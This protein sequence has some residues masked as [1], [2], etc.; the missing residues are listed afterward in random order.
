MKYAIV[1]LLWALSFHVLAQ[2][3]CLD[4]T[5]I[6][7]GIPTDAVF[8]ENDNKSGLNLPLWL[9]DG[10]SLA[11]GSRV[12]FI[13]VVEFNVISQQGSSTLGFNR[14]IQVGAQA[15]TVPADKVWKVEAIV[16]HAN[17]FAS[18]FSA[19]S[20]SPV[21]QGLQLNLSASTVN[22]ATYQWTGPNG[23]SSTAQNPVISNPTAAAA[24]TYTMTATLNGCTS[25]P[26][27]TNVVVHELPVSTFGH[28]PSLAISNTNITFTPTTAGATYAWTFDS[29]TPAS[30]S[31][32]NPV[33]QW[34]GA[35]NYDVTL[36]V[37]DSN[38][39]VS[40][41]TQVVSVSDCL[42]GQPS[43]AFTWNPQVPQTGQNVSFT[44]SATGLSYAW[45][46]ESG[47]SGTSTAESP[48]VSWSGTGSFEISLTVTDDGC[49]TTTTE[50]LV[51]SDPVEQ[52]YNFTGSVQNFT[53]PAGVTSVQV[54]CWGA[55]GQIG[56]L[57]ST[58]I[59]GLGGYA[60]GTLAVTPGQSLNIYV[61]G[62]S[63]NFAGGY[64]GGGSGGNGGSSW[65]YGGGGGGA[66]DVRVGGTSL[67]NRVIIAGGGGG[68]GGRESS[69]TDA[70]P[71]GHGGGNTG[72]AGTNS[73]SASAGQGGTQSAGG[74]AGTSPWCNGTAGSSG[75]GGL[76]QNCNSYSGGGGGGG[77]YGGGGGANGNGGAGGG[78]GSSFIGGVSGGSTTPGIRTGHGQV[79]IT[80]MP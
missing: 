24:G 43:S 41:T 30:S 36:T 32:V 1:S 26:S 3:P 79:K 6:I 29:G 63:T 51:V 45:T 20:N 64:N 73:Q 27:A 48:T 78:G 80:Y 19:S 60:T 69:S 17:A 28:S 54:E 49:F 65:G 44:P 68:G 67:S 76:G 62:K 38:G 5:I 35:G 72:N 57:T 71:G 52:V 2:S 13:S 55:E 8:M 40:T 70:G 53:V 74:A 10:T 18:G 21:C 37:T 56:N 58:G 66:S 61:G 11:A 23:F 4:G 34:T 31:A 77:Y 42:P 7:D 46:F 16:K 75:Q 9:S 33:V 59:G 15:E 14:V 22:G 39:C 12:H 50:T 25:T 47:S